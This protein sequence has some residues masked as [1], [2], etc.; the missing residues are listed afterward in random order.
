LYYHAVTAA[1]RAR[2][3]A[4]MDLL[5]CRAMPFEAGSRERTS[6][7][8]W[9]VAV[10]FDDGFRSVVDHAVPELEARNIPF[11]IF[12]PS[13]CLG[14]RPAWVRDRNHPAWQERVM[15][16][17]EL[18]TLAGL[19]LA[20]IGSHSVTHRNMRQ[21]DSAQAAEELVRS[22]LELQAAA[23]TDIDLFSF[24]HGAHN[25]ALLAQARQAGY[26]RVFTVQP[27]LMPPDPG[28][29]TVGRV[30]VDPNDWP[31]EFRLKLA[32]A[33]RWRSRWRRR[34]QTP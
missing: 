4:Q 29:F 2:F 32:G 7:D 15:S 10:T 16:A 18:R 8:G 3:A 19:P 9:H 28:V 22:R 17:A 26:R 11:T 30:A 27:A 13:G 31:I 23:G 12:V 33:Y 14:E 25:A 24:P 1:Q 5:R 34:P 6:D 21:L 20:T